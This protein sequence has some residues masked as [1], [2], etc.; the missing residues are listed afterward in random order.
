MSVSEGGN[1]RERVEMMRGLRERRSVVL[2]DKAGRRRRSSVKDGEVGEVNS[3]DG[4]HDALESRI[5]CICHG[6]SFQGGGWEDSAA[7]SLERARDEKHGS[8][9]NPIAGYVV[10]A[11]IN[12]HTSPLDSRAGSASMLGSVP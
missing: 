7:S 11:V 9:T 10:L 5:S 2:D 6:T 4:T 1:G 3:R 8:L 12:T